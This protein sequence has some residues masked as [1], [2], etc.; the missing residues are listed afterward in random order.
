MNNTKHFRDEDFQN[1]LD[2]NFEGNVNSFEQHIKECG[3]CSESLRIYLQ[4]WSFAK[5]EMKSKKLKM[6][7]AAAVAKKVFDERKHKPYLDNS[8]IG[9]MLVL[10]F[11]IVYWCVQKLISISITQFMGSLLI[12][13]IFYLILAYREMNLLQSKFNDI[14]FQN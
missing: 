8:L 11:L 14:K 10:S 4:V 9:G 1:Y 7:I 5:T 12:P 6:D 3:P 2:R 13:L